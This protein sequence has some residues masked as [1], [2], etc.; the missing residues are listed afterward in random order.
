MFF[1]RPYLTILIAGRDVTL[2]FE[3]KGFSGCTKIIPMLGDSLSDFFKSKFLTIGST[4]V[5]AAT[6]FSLLCESQILGLFRILYSLFYT[7]LFN[8]RTI[9]SIIILD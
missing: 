6:E 2:N 7:S 5:K 3:R 9:I 8:V 1:L 4:C